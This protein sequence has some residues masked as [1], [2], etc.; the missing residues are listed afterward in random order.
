MNKR[1]DEE[2]LRK[3]LTVYQQYQAQVEIIARELGLAQI[4][5]EGVERASLAIETMK[6][7]DLGREMLVPIGGGSFVHAKL[8][9]T[10][11]V[12]VNVGAGVSIEK[13]AAD[14]KEI[15]DKRKNDIIETSKKLTN[16]LQNIENE[17]A[18]VQSAIAKF[19]KAAG[20]EGFV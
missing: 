13:T 11:K 7:S 1:S 19:E 17:M 10:D 14:A 9:D 6:R 2:E 5:L 12:V 16:V 4:N 20:S 8:G 3:L 18:K 15:M